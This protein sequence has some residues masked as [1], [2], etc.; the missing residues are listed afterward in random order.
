[1][2]IANTMTT[3]VPTDNKITISHSLFFMT[4]NII[5]LAYVEALP[6]KR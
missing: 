3:A 1:M 4:K 6:T 5:T 2:A